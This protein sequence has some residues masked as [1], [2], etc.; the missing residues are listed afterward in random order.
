MKRKHEGCAVGIDLGTTYS[1]VAVWQDQHCRVE[2]IHNDQR[3]RTTPSFVA[4]TKEQRLVGDAAKN[5]AA[6]NPQNTIFDAKRLI[7]RKFSDPVVQDDILLWPFKVTAG[8]NDKPMITITYKDQE[9]QLY[10]EEVSSMVLAKM[11]EIAEAYL[12]SPVKSAVVTVPAYFNYSQR[13]ATRDAGTIAGLNVVRVM[14]EPTAAAVAYGL[15]KRI[16]YV[17]ERNIFVFDL[18]GG[19]FDVSLLR[20]KDNDFQVKATAGNTH[21]GGEDFDNRMVNYFVQEFKRKNKVDISGNPRALRRLRTACERAKRS[22]SFL[23]VTTIEVDSLL[24][25]IDFSSSINR[26]KF[27]EMNMDLFNECMNIVQSCLIDAKMDKSMIHDVVLVGGSSRIPIIQQLLQDFF[28]GKELCKSINPD[29]AVA[30]G[31]AVQAALLS[32][33]VKNVPNLVLQD[34]TPLSLGRSVQG[35]IMSVVIPRNTCIPVKMTKEYETIIDNQSFSLINVY[36]GERIRAS[37]NNLLGSFCLSGHT[38][39][40]RGHPYNVCF[41]IDENGIL[42]VSAEE[43]SAE[44]MN[45]ITI[46]NYKERLST[47]EIKK[48]IEE[49]ENY[50]IEDKNFLRKAKVVNAL[51]DY[52]YKMRNAFKKKD[53]DL[54]FSSEEVKKIEDAISVA[55]NLVDENNKH[56][57]IDVLEDHLKVLKSWMEHIIDKTF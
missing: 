53:F 1:C 6:S 31:A 3:N 43:T 54:K 56:V 36:E 42:T 13:K 35:D 40:P 28:N 37:E 33:D 18:G 27:E 8:V 50:L 48:L 52:I 22:L 32:D 49:A 10:A 7:G 25:G 44:K 4:F 11:R 5:Q 24:Q 26:A 9:K 30:Y 23:F 20:I 38:P 12:E 16:D 21:L 39:A 15:H 19:T 29:E 55:A 17:G 46:T 41:S 47:K 45:A 51:D 34:V 14:N 57:E 2:I